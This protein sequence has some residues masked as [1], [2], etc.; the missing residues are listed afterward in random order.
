MSVALGN[1][2][3]EKDAS[4][5]RAIWHS[6]DGTPDRLLCAID[7]VAYEMHAVVREAFGDLA[8]TVAGNLDR[9]P[10]HDIAVQRMPMRQP[11]EAKIDRSQFGCW[12]CQEPR[13]RDARQWLSS[14][15]DADLQAQLSPQGTPIFCCRVVLAGAVAR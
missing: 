10:G 7:L 13:A 5:C 14:Y 2:S 12:N 9:P 4:T 15:G 8:A 3:L 1:I 6:F 11:T